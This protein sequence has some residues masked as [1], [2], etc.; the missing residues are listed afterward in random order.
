[1]SAIEEG[2]VAEI[3]SLATN[4]LC[5]NLQHVNTPSS[6]LWPRTHH[7]L[8]E[9]SAKKKQEVWMG[10]IPVE[11]NPEKLRIF[12]ENKLQ[13]KGLQVKLMKAGVKRHGFSPWVFLETHGIR[14]LYTPENY[15]N[16]NPKS[17]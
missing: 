15:S 7:P 2:A 4:P 11:Q 9:K 17:H 12:R 3:E 10:C 1:M 8:L 6:L 13:N 16:R 5:F 14:N